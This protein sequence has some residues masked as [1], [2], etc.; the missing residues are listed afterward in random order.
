M[1]YYLDCSFIRKSRS[2]NKYLASLSHKYPFG[3]KNYNDLG[4]IVP[5]RLIEVKFFDFNLSVQ[6]V[7]QLPIFNDGESTIKI[8]FQTEV[9][10]SKNRHL[11]ER[12]SKHIFE[13]VFDYTTFEFNIHSSTFKLLPCLL[14]SK[15][16]LI[17]L[18]TFHS[19]LL[20]IKVLIKS[21][22]I[23]CR[24]FVNGIENHLNIPR[25]YPLLNYILYG[26]LK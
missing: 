19:I 26:I 16:N 7:F 1:F 18:K 10:Y 13:N 24:I 2:F 8:I 21:I 14:T 22:S 17:S 25:S 9:N 20:K 15:E 23:V 6:L 3:Y 5:S 4:F 11:F 12:F